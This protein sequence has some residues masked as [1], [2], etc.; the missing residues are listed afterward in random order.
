[1]EFCVLRAVWCWEGSEGMRKLTLTGIGIFTFFTVMTIAEGGGRRAVGHKLRDMYFPT[2]KTSYL[3]WPAVQ[4]VN[5]RLMPIQLQLV[6]LI[7]G[8]AA[9]LY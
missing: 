9:P 7:P 4:M 5:F 1:M 3:V 8:P 6:S 2:L